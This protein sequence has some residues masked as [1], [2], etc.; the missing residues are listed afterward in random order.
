MCMRVVCVSVRVCVR[1][2]VCACARRHSRLRGVHGSGGVSDVLS[3]VEH[4]EGE[5]G[6]EVT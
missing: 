5:S 3:G 4:A 1:V 2:C 6:Q